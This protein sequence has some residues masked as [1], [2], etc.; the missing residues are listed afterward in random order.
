MH[1]QARA[2]ERKRADGSRR[3]FPART[4]GG[5]MPEAA[6][7][8]TSALLLALFILTLLLPVFFHLGDLRLSPYRVFLL[9][10]FVPLL[11]R[12]V[13]G[14]A[15][16]LMPADIILGF[17]CLWVLVALYMNHG[18][19]RLPFAV[20][21]V[22]ELY[23]GYLVGRILVRN[24]ADYRIVFRYLAFGLVVLAPFVVIEMLTGRMPISEILRPAV[25]TFEKAQ[26]HDMRMGFYRAQAVFE[27][28]ILFGL[29]CS[30]AIA[31]LFYIY[32]DRLPKGLLLSGLA[33]GMTFASLSS[34][35]LLSALL[36]FGMAAWGWVT[37]NAWWTL[38]VLVGLAYV[39]VDLL[40]NRSPLAVLVTYLTFDA[41][42][43]YWRMHIW[44]YGTAEVWRNPVFG[45][46]LNDWI[47]PAWMHASVDNFWLLMAMR[48]GIPGIALLV[49]GFAANLFVIMRRTLPETLRTYRE[50]YVIAAIGLF[51]TLATVHMWGATAVFVMFYM[52]AGVWLANGAPEKSEE[53]DRAEAVARRRRM[54]YRSPPPGPHPEPESGELM[55]ARAQLR[56]RLPHTRGPRAR[57]DRTRSEIPLRRS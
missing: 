48:Y 56:R 55:P 57:S 7:A 46:G 19:D 40:S 22:T 24:E 18:A 43:A 32:R 10:M 8:P 47:R 35:P 37:R 33:T 21:T 6:A 29:F 9:V 23:G 17:Y 2:G 36:Q 34:A 14:R 5:A 13:G 28:P 54:A 39:V 26:L 12:L 41:H 1:Y 20:V 15:G 50:G 16:R 4:D 44:E 53:P 3:G 30:L 38:V 42:N 31:N 25:S 27:H 51:M 45:I 52:G 49:L 11:V